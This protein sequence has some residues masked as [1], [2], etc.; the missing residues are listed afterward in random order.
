[1]NK[2]F[3]TSLIFASFVFAGE[4]DFSRTNGWYAGLSAGTGSGTS[5]FKVGSL[6]TSDETDIDETP[7]ILKVGYLLQNQ[8]RVDI[9]YKSNSIEGESNVKFSTT[10]YGVNYNIGM[11]SWSNDIILPFFKVGA[12]VGSMSVDGGGL[13]DDGSVF[14]FNLG[15]GA[16]FKVH[17]NIDLLAALV[18]TGTSVT[19]D[20]FAGNSSTLTQVTTGVELGISYH[21]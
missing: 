4:P 21:F 19:G 5:Q 11:V 13:F 9:Y 7:I 18:R 8:D 12:G 6:F 15:F 10:T 16:N 20:T 3:V 2:I 17:E 1:M 14:E